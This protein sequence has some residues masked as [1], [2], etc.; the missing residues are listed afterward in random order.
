MATRSR[1]NTNNNN[2][3]NNQ[4]GNRRRN[5]AATGNDQGNP[6]KPDN[7]K[8]LADWN[9][10]PAETLKLKCAAN[11]LTATGKKLDLS[12][13]LLQ[14][15]H[16]DGVDRVRARRKNA[17][18]PADDD[19]LDAI[20][21]NPP[22]E[23]FRS[24]DDPIPVTTQNAKKNPVK[25]NNTNTNKEKTN[26]ADTSDGTLPYDTNDEQWNKSPTPTPPASIPRAN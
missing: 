18:K 3:H 10:L 8:S 14:F 12:L 16:P 23:I 25:Q 17:K 5:A 6:E 21:D 15:F 22:P 26:G 2:N 4:N 24:D 9:K 1:A 20:L 19:D 7:L 13:R 11:R